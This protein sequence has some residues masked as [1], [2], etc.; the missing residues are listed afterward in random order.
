MGLTEQLDVIARLSC[1]IQQIPIDRAVTLPRL[2][3]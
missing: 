1:F 2:A 3:S